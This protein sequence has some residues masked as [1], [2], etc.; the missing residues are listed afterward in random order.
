MDTLPDPMKL[1]LGAL[2]FV[3]VLITALFIF[4]K[5]V[6]FKPLIKVMDE[7]EEAIQSGASSRAEAAAL[8]ER[9][10]GEYATRLRDL[11]GQAFEHRKALASAAAKEKVT[12]LDRT[13]NEATATR[14]T[15][16]AELQAAKATAKTDLMAQVDALADSMVQHLLRQA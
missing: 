6:F 16:V 1:E 8:V 2:V 10:Q 7:R 12:I 3:I 11:R 15:A 5:Y 13:R 4:M 14:T 9:R